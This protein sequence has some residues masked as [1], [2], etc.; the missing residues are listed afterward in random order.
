M[1]VIVKNAKT[2]IFESGSANFYCGNKQGYNI[3]FFSKQIYNKF[4]TIKIESSDANFK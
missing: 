2:A 3:F 4:A 1:K